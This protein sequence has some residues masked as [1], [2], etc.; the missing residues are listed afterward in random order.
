MSP[1]LSLPPSQRRTLL[2][3]YRRHPSP[4]VR[5]RAHIILLLADGHTWE[6]I[7][8]VLFA[9]AATINRWLRRFQGGGVEALLDR[10]REARSRWSAEA[11]AILQAVLEHS[12]DA[13]GYLAVNWTVPLLRDHIEREWGQRPA[14]ACV[15][16]RLRD[17][18]YVWK[19]PGLD[20]RG[21]KTPRVRRRLRAIQKKVR[22][23]P[24]ACA[25]LFEDE[26]DL[27]L[28]P[29]LRAG[30]FLRGKP[31]KVPIT[32]QNAKRTVYGT[33]DVETGRRTFAVRAGIC[34]PDFHAA[35]RAIRAAYGDRP[36]ALLLDKA[37]RHTAHESKELASELGIELI[38]LPARAANINPMDRL[39]R[40]GKERVCANRQHP[41]IDSQASMFVDYL[42][43]LSPGEALRKA[44]LRAGRFWLFR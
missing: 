18:N 12:P 34:A 32:G 40:W 13:L 5:G 3:Y 15:R 20:L 17:L 42:A 25:K 9:S 37:S 26:T 22:A 11:E 1:T 36:V 14:D 28:F 16:R 4:E 33:I 44:G 43:G 19:R 39:W 8:Q 35:L 6:T 30:W 23:L 2:D 10:P 29:P 7:T 41:D 31:A 27:L 38:W 24:P 21:G